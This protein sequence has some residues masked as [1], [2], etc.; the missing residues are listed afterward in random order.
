[1]NVIETVDIDTLLFDQLERIA[2]P[3]RFRFDGVERDTKRTVMRFTVDTEEIMNA[4]LLTALA[5]VN[6]R[7]DQIR[8]IIAETEKTLHSLTFRVSELKQDFN[9]LLNFLEDEA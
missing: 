7:A 6:G 1:M 5:T 9:D 4:D 3:L 2:S 8:E